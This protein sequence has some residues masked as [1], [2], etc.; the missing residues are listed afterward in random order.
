MK[1][2]DAMLIVDDEPSIT[3]LLKKEIS[4]HFKET[5]EY[6]TAF[7][8]SQA[9]QIID[10]MVADGIRVILILSDWLMP[11]MKGDEFLMKVH[12]KHPGIRAIMISGYADPEAIDA[13]RARVPLR[14]FLG[15]P[16]DKVQ[17]ILEIQKC[18]AELEVIP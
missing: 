3:Y 4:R 16:W 14:A 6:E 13:V 5:F 2:R 8:A 9:L 17:L 7:S 15:K 11:E 10:A 12:A 1:N 18:I